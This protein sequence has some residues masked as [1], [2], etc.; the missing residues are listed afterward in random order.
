MPRMVL[1]V[2]LC[3][4]QRLFL[5]SW[6]IGKFGEVSHN[7]VLQDVRFTAGRPRH[8]IV[9]MWAPGLEGFMRRPLVVA[10]LILI[11]GAATVFAQSAPSANPSEGLGLLNQAAQR[12]TDAKAYYLESV[13]E[14]TSST[15]YSHSW[16]KTVI[17]AAETPE[18]RFHFE[19]HSGSGSGL[20]IADGKTVWTYRVDEHRYTDGNVERREPQEEFGRTDEIFQV[21]AAPSGCQSHSQWSRGLL[22]CCARP[23]LRPETRHPRLH[24]R[25]DN[26]D[27]QG[28]P[29]ICED[30]RARPHLHFER[31]RPYSDGRGDNHH[32]HDHRTE[33]S[34]A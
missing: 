23:K 2:L 7:P 4:V 6:I 33:R 21:S 1:A 26:L 11:A 15:E 17:T 5:K 14:R 31:R 3:K 10:V 25:E 22:R 13:E 32:L 24:V 28:P 8:S 18:N 34:T 19:G 12:Y 27:R 16:Q 30:G 29:D 9:R 20:K